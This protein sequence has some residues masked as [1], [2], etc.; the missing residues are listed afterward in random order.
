MRAPKA[1][2][3]AKNNGN[4]EY[5]LHSWIYKKFS[6]QF[7]LRVRDLFMQ[8]YASKLIKQIYLCTN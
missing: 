1:Y 5:M 4:L 6:P 2:I 3:I 8:T 7:V